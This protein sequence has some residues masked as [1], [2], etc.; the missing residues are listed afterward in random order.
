MSIRGVTIVDT[1]VKRNQCLSECITL[2]YT[3]DVGCPQY[4]LSL[5]EHRQTAVKLISHLQYSSES[6]TD[7]LI[8]RGAEEQ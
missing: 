4:I 1:V 8:K 3:S 7:L 6:N 2:F 5:N